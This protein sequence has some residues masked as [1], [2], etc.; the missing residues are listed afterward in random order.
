[1][2]VS[3]LVCGSR[4]RPSYRVLHL[5]ISRTAGFIMPVVLSFLFLHISALLWVVRFY[6]ISKR[7]NCKSDASGRRTRK[8]M[9]R[10]APQ[11]LERAQ[12]QLFTADVPCMVFLCL[13]SSCFCMYQPAPEALWPRMGVGFGCVDI[14]RRCA[15]STV[16]GSVEARGCISETNGYVN[17]YP[18]CAIW[19]CAGNLQVCAKLLYFSV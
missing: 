18:R 15:L 17:L 6:H 12:R 5:L 11:V 14:Y 1:M 2:P 19:R 10:C 16:A 9:E 3:Q 4:R 7:W 13:H 8:R